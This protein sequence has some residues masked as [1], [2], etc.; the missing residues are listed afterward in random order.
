M[1]GHF[2]WYGA[3]EQLRWVVAQPMG[4]G[5]G[6]L[7]VYVAVLLGLAWW[8]SRPLAI[9]PEATPSGI[10]WTAGGSTLLRYRRWA[11]LRHG[12]E[13]GVPFLLG[14]GACLLAGC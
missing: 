2:F 5:G 3:S 8:Q 6:A 14:L 13:V 7:L 11:G 12:I 1:P 4:V 9:Q 10:L